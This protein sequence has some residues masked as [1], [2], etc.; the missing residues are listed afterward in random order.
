MRASRARTSNLLYTL[1]SK[2]QVSRE[3]ITRRGCVPEHLPSITHTSICYLYIYKRLNLSALRVTDSRAF[4]NY[5]SSW[6][7]PAHQLCCCCCFIAKK[8]KHD[9]DECVC[10]SISLCGHVVKADNKKTSA[11]WNRNIARM[12]VYYYMWWIKFLV[13]VYKCYFEPLSSFYII[14]KIMIF[15]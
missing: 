3:D 6:F 11:E 13:F 8:K 10:V 12:E 2:D 9:D 7:M 1:I 15:V 5:L 14:K 4:H